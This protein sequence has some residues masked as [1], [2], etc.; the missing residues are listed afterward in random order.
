MLLIGL[1]FYL[2]GLVKGGDSFLFFNNNINNINCITIL[3]KNTYAR[4]VSL[5]LEKWK[6]LEEYAAYNGISLSAAI[7]RTS[8]VGLTYLKKLVEGDESTQVTKI[9]TSIPDEKHD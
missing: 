3:M 9:M 6:E 7:S 1:F 4:S 2:G 8:G 5:T